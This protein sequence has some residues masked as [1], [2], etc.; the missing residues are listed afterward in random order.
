MIEQQ[1]SARKLRDLLGDPEEIMDRDGFYP[2]ERRAMNLD[3]HMTFWR[4]PVLRELHD[5]KQRKRFAALLAMQ[6][7]DPAAM[8]SECLAPALWHEYGLSLC[9]FRPAPAPDTTAAKIAALM[10]G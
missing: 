8:C 6:P 9:L 1:A 2:A 10:P 7:V 3:S 4:H 5:G